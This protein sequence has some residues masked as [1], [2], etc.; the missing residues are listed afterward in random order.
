[1]RRLV[2]D[3]TRLHRIALTALCLSAVVFARPVE[4][5]DAAAPSPPLPPPGRLI[6]IGGWRLHLHCI[7]A[8]SDAPTVILEAGVGAF[9]VD[10][11]LVQPRVA[12]FAR[13]CA[14]DRA[15]SGWSDMGPHPRTMKQ[16]VWELHALLEK[17]GERP[18]FVLVG[19][20]FGGAL[21]RL[22]ASTFP[23]E[24]A[25][26]VLVDAQ[27]DDYLRLV[28]GREAMASTLATGR[29]VPPVKTSG[30]LHESDVPAEARRQIMAMAGWNAAHAN[31]PPRNKLP[32]D[33][34]RMRAWATAQLKHSA[35][36]DNPYEGDELVAMQAER[37]RT[38]FPLGDRP[39]IV[40]TRGVAEGSGEQND[41][42]LKDQAEL[43]TRSRAGR[44][45]IATK[46]GHHI[47]LDEPDL[48]AQAVRDALAAAR[49]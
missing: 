1:M 49:R 5:Q 40:V 2:R 24:V 22:Y 34:Q 46:S 37:K 11:A 29:P 39:L 38:P 18:P 42:R 26:M 16:I 23:T 45:I 48:V 14:Y 4:A 25:G 27:H 13:V 30:P 31:D 10:W 32:P 28:D 41:A 44:Q 7:G 47:D 9:S 43:A 6:D 20:S 12:A 3:R 19:H 36:N 15:G 35:S 21:V 8:V 33:A 17:A